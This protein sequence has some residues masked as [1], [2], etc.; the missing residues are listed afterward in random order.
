MIP[1]SVVTMS[2]E[3]DP[4]EEFEEVLRRSPLDVGGPLQLRDPPYDRLDGTLRRFDA[5]DHFGW[6]RESWVAHSP[7]YRRHPA[8][9]FAV[10]DRDFLLEDYPPSEDFLDFRPEGLSREEW[11][12][13]LRANTGGKVPHPWLPPSMP[14]DAK[15]GFLFVADLDRE[16]G[17]LATGIALTAHGLGHRCVASVGFTATYVPCEGWLGRG[18]SYGPIFDFG[19][20]FWKAFDESF[21][22]ARPMDPHR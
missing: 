13:I 2:I 22:E 5:P 11:K 18:P 12:A 17:E 14:V 21:T 20:A 19:Y 1:V 3:G 10:P 16:D 15:Y 4:V 7:G 6:V 9:R 8:A